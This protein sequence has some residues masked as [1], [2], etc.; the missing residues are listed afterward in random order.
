LKDFEVEVARRGEY[1]V[2]RPVGELD[3]AAV[4]AVERALIPLES[5]FTEIVIDLRAVEFLDSAGLR[6]ILACDARA[7]Q[8]GFRLR[9]INGGN[10]VQ[11]LLSLT[12]M[13]E[14]LTLV[15]P[16]QLSDRG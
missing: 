4:D 2:V 12:G 13:D 14:H 1:V 15:D 10:Q 8:D 9:I 3:L 7:R 11:K 5:E 16:D 6:A